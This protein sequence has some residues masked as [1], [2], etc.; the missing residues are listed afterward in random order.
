MICTNEKLKKNK[1][2]TDKE[3]TYFLVYNP[4]KKQH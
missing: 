2:T 3:I 1:L 4:M